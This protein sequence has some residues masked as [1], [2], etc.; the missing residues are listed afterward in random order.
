MSKISLG[1]LRA[2]G[3]TLRFVPPPSPKSVLIFYPHT[4]NWDF[5]IGLLARGGTGLR[6]SFVGKHTLFRWPLGGLMRRLGGIPID[7]S[8]RAGLVETLAAEFARRPSFHVAIAPEGTRSRGDHWR[9]GFYRLALAA[10][11]P[12]GL[13]FFDYPRRE[14][15]IEHWLMMTGD[16]DADL[17]RIAAVYAGREGR[18]PEQQTPIRFER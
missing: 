7:R 11:V 2:C 14:I 3:W 5:P 13:G 8:T 12:V 15:G 1:L 17:A 4:S 16:V 9:T 6:V 10:Q 18:N